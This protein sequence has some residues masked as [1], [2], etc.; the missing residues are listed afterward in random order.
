MA[1]QTLNPLRH[2]AP[3]SPSQAP[4]PRQP[5]L[6]LLPHRRLAGGAA[7]PRAVAVA[8]SGPIDES[9]RRG[10]PLEGG[11]KDGKETDLATL[12]NLCVDVVLNVPQLPPVQRDERK[13]YMERLAASPPD[14]VGLL[15]PYAG[16]GMKARI[17]LLF[18]VRRQTLVCLNYSSLVGLA[19]DHGH[20]TL[21]T[22]YCVIVSMKSG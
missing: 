4:L 14:Q 12:G 16:C 5:L 15:I 13:A 8:F 3:V 7:R 11:G 20:V 17:I 9:K 1:L 19:L 18:A 10:P 2:P 22:Q 21:M 6:H